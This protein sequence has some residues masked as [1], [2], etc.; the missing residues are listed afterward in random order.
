MMASF[1]AMLCG[2]QTLDRSMELW[3]WMGVKGG[4]KV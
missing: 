3:N 4:A 2:I 1:L